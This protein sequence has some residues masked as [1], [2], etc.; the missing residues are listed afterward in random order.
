MSSCTSESW[1]TF[2]YS[3]S[4]LLEC[5]SR[6]NASKVAIREVARMLGLS[7]W[8][9]HFVPVSAAARIAARKSRSE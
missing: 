5:F 9:R 3:L 6:R 2:F 1:T 4:G 8:C 7:S